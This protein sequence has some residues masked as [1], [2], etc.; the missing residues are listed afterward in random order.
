VCYAIALPPV[1][2]T[3]VILAHTRLGLI[4]LGCAIAATPKRTCPE[5][6]GGISIRGYGAIKIPQLFIRGCDKNGCQNTKMK[7]KRHQHTEFSLLRKST[8]KSI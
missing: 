1:L 5:I 2:T 6:G 8:K 4:Y 3:L 7:S